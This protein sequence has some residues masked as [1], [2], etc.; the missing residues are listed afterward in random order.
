[1]TDMKKYRRVV[2]L[3]TTRLYYMLDYTL[4]RKLTISPSFMT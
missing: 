2:R 1:M 3:L 4:N